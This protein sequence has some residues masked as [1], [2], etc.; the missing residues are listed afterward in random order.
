MLKPS[1]VW[2]TTNSQKFLKRLEY[3][4]TLPVLWEI[5]MPTK[6]QQLEQNMKQQTGWNWERSLTRL[7]IATL[8]I[9]LTRSV[10]CAVLN[11]SSCPTLCELMDCSLPGSSIHGILQARILEW[12]AM[13]SSRGYSQNRNQTQVSHIAGG[14]FTSWATREACHVI[15]WAGWITG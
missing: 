1:T 6:K 2:I 15:C 3:Q 5:W 11:R 10:S 13:P 4:T 7:F 12:V 9:W 8:L 14:F